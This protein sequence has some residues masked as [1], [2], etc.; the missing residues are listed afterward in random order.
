[1]LKKCIFYSQEQKQRAGNE[2]EIYQLKMVRIL[3]EVLMFIQHNYAKM[4]LILKN[5]L[6]MICS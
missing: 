6:K 5:T 2:E 4:K 1:M 3:K